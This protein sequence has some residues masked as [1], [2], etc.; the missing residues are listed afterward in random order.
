M[1]LQ[2]G[3]TTRR[4]ARFVL[5]IVA[6]V[7]LG[8][9][10]GFAQMPQRTADCSAAAIAKAHDTFRKLSAEGK[11]RDAYDGLR[12][13]YDE[14]SFDEVPNASLINDLA[15]AAHRLDDDLACLEL[16]ETLI[17]EDRAP[18]LR[19]D[20]TIP[21]PM[22]RAIRQSVAVCAVNGCASAPNRVSPGPL[23]PA[24]WASDCDEAATAGA[25]RFRRLLS[26]G[27]NL[28]AYE[29]L[30]GQVKGCAFSEDWLSENARLVSDLAFAAHRLGDDGACLEHLQFL[31]EIENRKRISP[32]SAIRGGLR[33]AVLATVKACGPGASACTTELC[34]AL[35]ERGLGRDTCRIPGYPLG[36]HVL[37]PKGSHDACLV[38]AQPKGGA[39]CDNHTSRCCATL[40][41]IT[42]GAQQKVE[43]SAIAL[44]K[45]SFLS[46][47]E[48]CHE[49]TLSIRKGRVRL[50]SMGFQPPCGGGTAR[51]SYVELF[52]WDGERVRDFVP[53][54]E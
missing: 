54:G 30:A 1:N 6:I 2:G 29:G 31:F 53:N 15:L 32:R 36:V 44:S 17:R 8:S 12:A 18:L 11:I 41:L 13:R 35:R 26:K 47:P 23:C 21:A 4:C 7:S 40:V 43:S 33:R 52:S 10:E 38:V 46:G 45:E 9:T 20:A 34:F 37:P 22:E 39:D 5:G 3:V 42:R 28:E 48:C 24:V 19:L 49:S 14:C 16:L 25:R 51:V 27:K 50:A